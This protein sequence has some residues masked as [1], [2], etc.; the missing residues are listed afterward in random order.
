MSTGDLSFIVSVL[1]AKTMTPEKK[2]FTV[3]LMLN[4]HRDVK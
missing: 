1:I 3:E 4:I 2:L